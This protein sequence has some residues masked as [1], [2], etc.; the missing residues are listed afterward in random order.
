MLRS[1]KET[2]V[3]W[4]N[5]KK[6]VDGTVESTEA[7]EEPNELLTVSMPLGLFKRAFTQRGLS[8]EKFVKDFNINLLA[9]NFLWS[10]VPLLSVSAKIF[11][12]NVVAVVD[13]GSSGVV[14]SCGCVSRLG[15]KPDDLVEMN[16]ASLNGVEKKS[17]SV[18]FDVPIK[19]G[20]SLV[21]LPTLVADGLFVDVLL[22]ANWLKAVGACLDVSQLELVVD[23]EKLKLKK[24]PNPSK[25]FVGSSFKMYTKRRLRFLLV[26]LFCVA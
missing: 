1:G 18:F 21:S 15:L 8:V 22:G 23:S 26:P 25:D 9:V 6:A 19:V 12:K 10:D 3:V 24:L 2:S 20:H 5:G 13:S 14:I 11:S 16:I 17:R 4:T 7:A